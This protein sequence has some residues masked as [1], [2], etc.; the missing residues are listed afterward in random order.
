MVKWSASMY[1]RFSS[2][3]ELSRIRNIG[4]IAHIDAGKTTT[5]ERMLYYS[6]H[7]KRIGEV[8]RG[9]T[10]M[11]YLPEERARGI[12]ISSSAI[13][14]PWKGHHINLIDTP[15]HVDFGIEVERSLRVMDGVVCI[16][17]GR[18]GVQAQTRTVWKQADQFD[19]PRIIFVNKLDKPGACFESCLRS[20]EERLGTLAL[21]IQFPI[22]SDESIRIVDVLNQTSLKFEPPDGA[23]IAKVPESLPKQR[24]KLLEKIAELDDQFLETYLDNTNPPV[25]L[26][27]DAISR[28]T[29]NRRVVPVL[30]GASF[31]NIGVQPL[32]DAIIDYLPSPPE[33]MSKDLQMLAFKCV[34][35]HQKGFLVYVRVY[36]GTYQTKFPLL[37][38]SNNLTEKPAKL[39]QVYADEF[40]EV[41]E[42]GPGSI[43]IL[44]GLKNTK[45]GDT[46]ISSYV[47]KKKMEYDMKPIR[48]P[49]AVFF[50]SVEP[51][52]ISEEDNMNVALDIV[53]KEDPSIRMSVDPMTGQT[54]LSGIGELHLEI[55]QKRIVN[56][57]K[58]KAIFG[59]VQTAFKERPTYMAQDNINF[60]REI[61]GSQLGADLSLT[62]EPNPD[63]DGNC[64]EIIT[65]EQDLKSA[66][67]DAV[68][69]NLSCS[70][71]SNHPIIGTKVTIKVLSTGTSV[72]AA[73]LALSSLFKIVLGK[74]RMQKLE[75][76]MALTIECLN[77]NVGLIIND[78]HS[79]R[80]A[81][82]NLIRQIDLQSQCIEAEA[83]L[84]EMLGY[85]G[86]LRSVSQGNASFSLE[87][88]GFK[89]F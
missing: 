73:C 70:P 62:I 17:D 45:T 1:R 26:I 78:L 5:T 39:Y 83:P 52:S 22:I 12:T 43:G 32:L 81:E 44:A 71:L 65:M 63:S 33:S 56:D 88:L 36:S 64:I 67:M 15:G 10:V 55:V 34:Y 75:P 11:D 61:N 85:S 25:M 57:L 66:L 79:K 54:L 23:H 47:S 41:Q 20:I 6:G 42:L 49:P 29:W 21:P 86:Y 53:C 72:Q 38:E 82:V 87:P 4:I 80:R 27:S 48:V 30:C 76:V 37:N 13:T 3:T 58:A 69:G 68:A 31:K 77:E 9:D 8:D 14:F 2:P 19:L 74:I 18:A 40:N 35:D 51:E 16:L 28:L 59:R 89:V 84:S 7:T 46:L 60:E 24:E 50:C